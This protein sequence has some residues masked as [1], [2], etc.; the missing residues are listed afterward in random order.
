M[1]P[2]LLVRPL[3]RY[4]LDDLL[5]E[6]L[7]PVFQCGAAGVQFRQMRGQGHLPLLT[8]PDRLALSAPSARHDGHSFA[9]AGPRVC[10]AALLLPP[11]RPILET[12]YGNRPEQ[13]RNSE[14]HGHE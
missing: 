11:R 9:P 8:L 13:G 7:Q 12:V 10:V 4:G 5:R 3:R 1:L 6:D 2:H 14:E